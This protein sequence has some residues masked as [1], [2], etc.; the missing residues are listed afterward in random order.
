MVA[1]AAGANASY[2]L[3]ITRLATRV[4]FDRNGLWATRLRGTST[5]L[6]HFYHLLSRVDYPL[7]IR[8][9]L[10]RK[11]WRRPPIVKMPQVVV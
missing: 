9:R 10:E 4:L 7:C 1:V 2:Y 11:R 8:H 3:A 6:S 5:F